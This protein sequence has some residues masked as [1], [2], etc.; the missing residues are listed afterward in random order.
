MTLS[1]I[2]RN[3][4][5]SG[6]QDLTD[7]SI[8][9]LFKLVFVLGLSFFCLT[10]CEK[11]D[12]NKI[13]IEAV[14]G[15][16]QK[17]PFTSGAQIQMHGLNASLS[18]TGSSFNS[19]VTSDIGSF[20]IRNI[21][22][23][24][25]IVALS[26][27][28]FYFNEIAGAV[29]HSRL[30]L[31]ALSDITK[32]TTINVNVLTHLEKR[33]VEYL[34]NEEGKSFDDAKSMAQSEVLAVFGF[35]VD[36]MDDSESLDYINDSEPNAA[37][38]AISVIL[39]GK[40]GVGELSELLTTISDGMSN[41]GVFYD[42]DVI[43]NLRE[44]A[45]A[46]NM[47]SIRNNLEARY[48]DLAIEATIPD[49]EYFIEV[50]LNH[51]ATE[52]S[53]ITS[54]ASDITTNS[55]TLNGI[56]DPG[57]A[58]TEVVFEY[59]EIDSDGQVKSSMQKTVEFNQ[60]INSETV[61]A[62]H[63][64]AGNSQF[65]NSATADQSPLNGAIEQHVSVA[66]EGLASGTTYRF[67]L[68]AENEIGVI[69]S[70]EAE[71]ITLGAPPTALTRRAT[72]ITTVSAVLNALVNPNHLETT[73]KFEYGL[74]DNLGNEAVALPEQIEGSTNVSVNAFIDN[75]APGTTFYYRVVAENELGI[76]YGTVYFFRS[77]A[78]DD[79]QDLDG[80]YYRTVIIGN[81]EWLAENLR[82]SRY[83]N[84]DDIPT[85]LNETEWRNTREGAY[86]IYPHDGGVTEWDVEGIN[87]D[88][89]MVEVYGK[90]Y[91]WYAV[92]DPRGMCPE[93][94]HIPT[95]DET[96]QLIDY[97]ELQGYPNEGANPYGAA[98]ALKTCRQSGSPLGGVCNTT[99]H[100]YWYAH[101]THHGFDEFGF[102]AYPGGFRTIGGTYFDLRWQ[103]RWWSSTEYSLSSAIS[104]TINYYNGSVG[105]N[106]G[107]KIRGLSV[108]CVKD[109]E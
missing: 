47:E 33:R 97:I 92:A 56:V 69:Y 45:L 39:Q 34:V 6:R 57:S 72:G 88:A 55:A 108:R 40:R 109:I 75:L 38:L 94:W 81:Q 32:H 78:E 26:A 65:S 11:D 27:D 29:S 103:A 63:S 19:M 66:I 98:N 10:A 52:P 46:L 61:S 83:N 80:N 23:A 2:A 44:T 71:F 79:P 49:F 64:K 35:D 51:S 101:N 74:S 30:N 105:T 76:S 100:P 106:V 18:Q 58:K 41:S 86:A 59:E 99:E 73:L 16:V 60:A 62:N 68:R 13:F 77:Y 104:R 82:V 89:E 24:S 96:V 31:T 4:A 50:F 107:P 1:R 102:S 15:V 67:R 93:G 21:E 84:G 48:A 90:L 12:P 25:S 36:N 22:I 9:L 14:S 91:N 20:K 28:G 95:Y 87:S 7:N 5:R 85:G 3:A 37:L 43:G 54:P 70:D 42:E 53:A 8:R 17:G